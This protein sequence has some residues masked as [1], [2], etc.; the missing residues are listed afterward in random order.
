MA[1]EPS[2]EDGA[3]FEPAERRRLIEA[4][5]ASETF[6]KS[7]RARALL[8]Y[9]FERQDA[10]EAD[11]VKG[12]T[13]A[14]DVFGRDET[15]D[16]NNDALV[17]VHMG[18]LRDLLAAYY[19]DEGADSGAV[20]TVPKGRYVLQF[21]PRERAPEL[22]AAADIAH[23]A[24]PASVSTASSP[25]SADV[26]GSFDAAEAA[27]ISKRLSFLTVMVGLLAVGAIAVY[28]LLVTGSNRGREQA[29][30][31]T[32]QAGSEDAVLRNLQGVSGAELLP[33]VNFVHSLGRDYLESGQ[34]PFAL[35]FRATLSRF[36]TIQLI[37]NGP[38]EPI[39]A[40][41][42]VGR[43]Y[44]SLVVSPI[45]ADEAERQGEAFTHR[46][47]L[48]HPNSGQLIWSELINASTMRLPSSQS[49]DGLL[50]DGS[51]VVAA[52][53]VA[54]VDG[55]V[56][57]HFVRDAGSNRLFDCL[58]LVSPVA[59]DLPPTS[60]EAAVPCLGRLIASGNQLPI[61]H[62]FQALAILEAARAG[63][64]ATASGRLPVDGVAEAA[65]EVLR[66]GQR[67]APQSA[68][69]YAVQAYAT[70]FQTGDYEVALG[71]SRNA[72]RNA[73]ASSNIW[74]AHVRMLALAG[75]YQE[76]DEAISVLSEA[77]RGLQPS[78][79]F[80]RFLI[81][82]ER[83]DRE[84]LQRAVTQ[85]SGVS[86][87]FYYLARI[88]AAHER[89]DFGARDAMIERLRQTY[90]AFY[91]NPPIFVRSMRL[92]PE[93]EEKLLSALRRA[94]VYRQG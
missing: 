72:I 67:A 44:Y 87:P 71:I 22:E 64:S 73:P 62:A 80:T 42:S 94:E 4:I 43:H 21:S 5:V 93:L 39:N 90:P 1:S 48:S 59:N 53:R 74:G 51:L 17:R 3:F 82:L 50:P 30:V 54:A 86:N 76:A 70:M 66:R 27:R 45:E 10:G 81:L 24:P 25:L 65:N 79:A 28:A 84:D 55:M 35:E 8:T 52:S 19:A 2:N 40:P 38:T 56:I 89:T 46:L 85:L 41:P 91:A 31:E 26:V 63:N 69:L 58:A 34:D 68:M 47:E 36:D 78:W 75:K 6:A 49:Q 12:F 83:G 61:T 15:F 7:E 33:R 23:A 18:R 57:S 16:P 37:A 77:A 60:A 88:V 13:I 92:R 32:A 11:Q 29:S 20:L 14:M 9:L